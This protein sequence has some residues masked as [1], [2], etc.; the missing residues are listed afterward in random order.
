[1]KKGTSLSDH[2]NEFQGIIDQML[3]M[4]IKF[5]D[6]I[7]GLL[8]LNSLL[9]SW[10]IFKVSITNLASNGVVSLQMVKGSILNKEI[11]RK[12]QGSSSQSEENKG[13]KGKSKEKDDDCVTTTTGDGLVILRD[14]ESVNFVF[15]ESM[16]I[17]D[18]G[19]TLHVTPRKEFFTSYTV[20]DFG[21]LKIGNDGVT[22]MISVGDVCLQTNIG[23]QLWLKGVKHA[24]DIRFNLIYMHMLD[25]GGYDNHFGHEKWK[26]TKGNLDMARGEKKFLNYI[27]QKLWLLMTM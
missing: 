18:S 16:W 1:F 20:G 3:G 10:E 21:V 14:F 2:L 7:L 24:L 22:K 19:A 6:E 13:K 8:L 27:G 26:I 4:S 17:I 15:D 9:E 11:R 12:A 5:E 25:D 23:M